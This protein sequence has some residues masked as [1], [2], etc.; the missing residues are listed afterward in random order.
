MKKKIFKFLFIFGLICFAIGTIAVVGIFTY[1]SFKVPKHTNLED[2]QPS[3][4]SRLYSSDGILLK[5]Y[6][7]EIKHHVETFL[8]NEKMDFNIDVYYESEKLHNC[9]ITYDIAFLDIEMEPYS[10]IAIAKELK[11]I[12]PY[13]TIFIITSYNKYRHNSTRSLSKLFYKRINFIYFQIIR[14]Y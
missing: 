4:T 3:I 10:G 6:A 11:S 5:E 8:Y 7:D 2:Y 12:N 13:I 1:Y 9:G 14:I